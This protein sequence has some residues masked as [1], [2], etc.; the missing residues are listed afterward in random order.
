MSGLNPNIDL[1]AFL[2]LLGVIQGLILSCFFLNRKNRLNQPNIFFGLLMLSFA[3]ISLDIFL[4]YTKY[5]TR[6]AYLDNFSE[7]LTFI[8][9]PLYY[10]YT[11]S[12]IKGKIKPSQLWHFLPFV[13]YSAYLLLY[14]VQPTS[15]KYYAY[16]STYFPQLDLQVV[17]PRFD[18]DPLHLRE[19]MDI[20]AIFQLTM[21][22]VLSIITILKAFKAEKISVFVKKYKNLSWLR[23]FS[24]GLLLLVI[25]FTLA[26]LNYGSDLGDYLITSFLT[27][28]IYGTSINVIR[29]SVF[30]TDHLG[31]AF[32]GNRKYAKSSLSEQDKNEILKRLIESMEHEKYYRNNSASQSQISKKLL[33]PAH[34]I[35]QVINEKLNQS[36]FE[37]IAAYRIREAERILKDPA[38]NHLTV[39]EVAEEVGYLSKSA[40]NKAFKKVTGKTPSEYR[41]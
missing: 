3:L 19:N 30:F 9:A 29:S 18:P 33:I 24:I 15:F 12:S 22:I 2:I 20:L 37:F 7:S 27:L 39:E 38:M 28:I 40:F 35:S 41:T 5:M 4:C 31:T 6:C 25:V 36:F 32:A 17:S 34:H 10:L 23:N 14:I 21:Y 13:F 16:T 26:D 11:Y 8:I 1:F